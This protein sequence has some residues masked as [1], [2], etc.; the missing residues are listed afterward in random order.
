MRRPNEEGLQAKEDLSKLPKTTQV[1]LTG[2]LETLEA[3]SR[4]L[5]QLVLKPKL[6]LTTLQLTT[7]QLTTIKLRAE[8]TRELTP[9]EVAEILREVKAEILREARVEVRLV[10]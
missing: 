8:A 9:L 3:T 7:L 2:E 6:R 4:Q 1:S 10:V 5:S